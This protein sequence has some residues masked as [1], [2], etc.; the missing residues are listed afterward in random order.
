[1]NVY[2][3]LIF[4]YLEEDNTQRAYFR[5]KPL[6]ATS[7]DIRDKRPKPPGPTKEPCES[8]RTVLSNTISRTACVPL[9]PIA[10]WT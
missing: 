2:Q 6:L 7:G 10:S 9:A 8:Y 4:S 1:M 3:E 5:V